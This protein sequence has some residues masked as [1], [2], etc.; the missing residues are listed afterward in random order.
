MR[1]RC[2]DVQMGAEPRL[3][4]SR[5]KLKV[6]GDARDRRCLAWIEARMEGIVGGFGRGGRREI[7]TAHVA[8]IRFELRLFSG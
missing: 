8:I 6:A 7:E 4:P 1:L 2:A 3:T 5:W